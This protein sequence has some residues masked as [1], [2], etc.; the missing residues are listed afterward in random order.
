MNRSKFQY[1]LG[2]AAALFVLAGCA[3]LAVQ[4]S[5]PAM[6]SFS[7]IGAP[8]RDVDYELSI[9]GPGMDTITRELGT[10]TGRTTL[11]VPSGRNRTFS[12]TSNDVY[13]GHATRNLPP[14]GEVSIPVRLLPGPVVPYAYEEPPN[15]VPPIETGWVQL[16]DLLVPDS[17][18]I[19]DGESNEGDGRARNIERSYPVYDVQFGSDGLL[20]S[21][22]EP[23]K[24]PSLVAVST[25]ESPQNTTV[26][27]V[28]AFA[29]SSLALDTENGRV[30]VA[31]QDGN[32]E[33]GSISGGSV[34][35]IISPGIL[36]NITGIAFGSD[37]YLYVLSYNDETVLSKVD[38]ESGD[39]VDSVA[40]PSRQP[41]DFNSGDN[42]SPWGD[43]KRLGDELL[44]ALSNVVEGIDPVIY[45]IGSELEILESFGTRTGDETPSPGEFWGPRRFA[46][47]RRENELIVVDQQ[48]GPTGFPGGPGPGRLVKFNF[49]STSDW[50]VFG[51]SLEDFQPFD[52]AIC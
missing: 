7:L 36:G 34:A 27:E 28:D 21:Y 45:R 16:R 14:G 6:P 3:D 46:A 48:D 40:I 1:L 19:D 22:G 23:G 29:F 33:A 5:T 15:G 47:V 30:A 2:V 41:T 9:S 35:P 32:L 11:E 52:T 18:L 8:D 50:Q 24:A 44:V 10:G 39:V 13:S 31:D 26:I 4:E 51:E 20:W 17:S 25:L 49:G 43:V 37:G 12:V 38:S 42:E